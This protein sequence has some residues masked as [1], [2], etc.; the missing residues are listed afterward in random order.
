MG[1]EER[2]ERR[3]PSLLYADDLILCGES[4]EDLKV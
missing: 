2:R 3:L 4:D 1:L